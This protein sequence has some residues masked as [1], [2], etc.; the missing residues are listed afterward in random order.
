MKNGNEPHDN[1]TPNRLKQELESYVFCI[2]LLM[3][4]SP[5]EPR[6]A[7]GMKSDM[8]FSFDSKAKL[9]MRKKAITTVAVGP[10]EHF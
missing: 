10:K 2:L 3:W 1:A 4:L 5:V 8:D 6:N 7:V 9:K